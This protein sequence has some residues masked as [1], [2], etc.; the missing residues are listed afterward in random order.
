M[1]NDATRFEMVCV[2]GR[3]WGVG[4]GRG[5]GGRR[6]RRGGRIAANRDCACCGHGAC[7]VM[8]AL[9]VSHRVAC[10]AGRDTRVMLAPRSSSPTFGHFPRTELWCGALDRA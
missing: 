7:L 8:T 4:G 3:E 9:R 5:Q 10:Q 1:N 6:K 2:W